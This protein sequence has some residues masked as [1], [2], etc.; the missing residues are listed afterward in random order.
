MI[1]NIFK[2]HFTFSWRIYV[3]I[4]VFVGIMA[5]VY[6][7]LYDNYH[8]TVLKTCGWSLIVAIIMFLLM[9]YIGLIIS[10]LTNKSGNII[11]I[12]KEEDFLLKAVELLKNAKNSLY[13]YGGM[14]LIGDNKIWKEEL[15]KKLEDGIFDV[16]RLVDLKS[17]EE[18]RALLQ[19]NTQK[20]IEEAT[21][22]YRNWVETHAN[23]VPPIFNSHFYD[24]DGAPIWRYAIHFLIFDKKHIAITFPTKNMQKNAIFLLDRPEEA[25]AL[26]GCI[27]NLINY[28]RKQPL[29][30]DDILAKLNNGS[31][32]K[33]TKKE[34]RDTNQVG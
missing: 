14:G 21:N 23:Y 7:V 6:E 22:K 16:R 33:V 3:G 30:R 24:F 32:E 12:D 20:E 11:F 26:V 4:G 29:E 25:R 27:K 10:S 28:L 8:W 5:F 1:K 19:K 9:L 17:C 15:E 34:N 13:Y 18:I 2:D 31:S